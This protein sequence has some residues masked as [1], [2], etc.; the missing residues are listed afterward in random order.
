MVEGKQSQG[1]PNR[2]WID[3]IL[4]WYNI[5]VQGAATLTADSEQ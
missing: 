3:D 2:R 4:V 1:K 5:D